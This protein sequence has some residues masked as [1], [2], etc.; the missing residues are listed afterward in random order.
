ML[1]Y[2]DTSALKRPFDEASEP[3]IELEAGA[4]LSILEAVETGSLRLAGSEVLRL[5]R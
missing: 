2:C 1:I 4:V 5:E 3:R